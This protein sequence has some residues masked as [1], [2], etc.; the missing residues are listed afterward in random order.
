MSD[1]PLTT[2]DYAL[3]GLLDRQPVSGYDIARRF[4]TTPMAHF[5]SSPGAIYP[6]LLRLDRAGLV[7]GR[8]DR[9]TET[10]PRRVYR[11]TPAGRAALDA[12]LRQ[13]VTRQELVRD[14]RAPILR[15]SFAEGR[16]SDGELLGYLEGY[17]RELAGYLLELE[18]FQT[19]M[20][21]DTPHQRLA[22][23]HGIRAYESQLAWIAD[24][25]RVLQ[26]A[27]ASSTRPE[28]EKPCP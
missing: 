9:A 13:P 14:G 18:R 27:P 8:L 17:R 10:R 21:D 25:I 2:L 23:D 12:W 16:L 15:F 6:A 7:A 28:G 26:L 11:L 5:S 19:A 3:L 24:A 4:A 1:R 20:A 22:L